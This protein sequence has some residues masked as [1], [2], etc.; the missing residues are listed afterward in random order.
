MYVARVLSNTTAVRSM[1]FLTYYR[2]AFV[3]C[4]VSQKKR[5][6]RHYYCCV[7]NTVDSFTV[8]PIFGGGWGVS[9]L[10]LDQHGMKRTVVPFCGAIWQ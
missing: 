8:S 3:G 10:M 1:H 5:V 9:C 7:D 6:R 4:A 2:C